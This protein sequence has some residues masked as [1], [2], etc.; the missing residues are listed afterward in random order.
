MPG[1]GFGRAPVASRMFFASIGLPSTVSPM[2]PLCLTSLP[3]P[4][5]VSILF[6]LKR[7]S[8]PFCCFSAICRLRPIIFSKSGWA[9]PSILIPRSLACAMSSTTSAERKSALVGMQPQLVQTPP[10]SAFSTTATFIP[11]CAARIAAT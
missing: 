11:S 9:E 2:R 5:S 8:I 10:S 7:N 1:S 4:R 6:F 3:V